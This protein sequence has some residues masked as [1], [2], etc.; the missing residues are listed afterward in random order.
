M[1]Y[2]TDYCRR[3]RLGG[4][5]TL[6]SSWES[7]PAP[8]GRHAPQQHSGSAFWS[9]RE[10]SGAVWSILERSEAFWSTMWP[11]ASNPKDESYHQTIQPTTQNLRMLPN[12]NALENF[13]NDPECS[14]ECS[15]QNA[16]TSTGACPVSD[17]RL[18]SDSRRFDSVASDFGKRARSNV[19]RCSA[20]RF[21]S[22]MTN[23]TP[24]PN[25]VANHDGWVS[26][27]WASG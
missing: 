12:Q 2:R 23:H 17:C 25:S 6:A 15:F 14:T 4:R 3:D 10:H 18:S 8:Q 5:Q 27:S 7:N 22:P 21:T 16:H 26:A 20:G 1:S 19:S 9:S 13:Q 11:Y 24:Q